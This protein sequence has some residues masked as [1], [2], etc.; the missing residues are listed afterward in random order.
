MFSESDYC[1]TVE[2][3]AAAPFE[4]EAWPYAMQ[5]FAQAGGGWGAQIM[6]VSARL[7]FQFDHVWGIPSGAA[8]DFE[9][10]GGGD[11]RINPWASISFREVNS[12]LG[13]LDLS[14]ESHYRRSEF[15]NEFL[16][17]WDAPFIGAA[18]IP[19][20]AG[21]HIVAA[22]TRNEKQGHIQ[23]EDVQNIGRVLPHVSAAITLQRRLEGDAAKIATGTLEAAA[24]AAVLCDSSGRVVS[25]TSG[26]EEIIRRGNVV[27]QRLSRIEATDAES[28]VALQR[29]LRHAALKQTAVAGSQITSVMLRGA[30]G[31]QVADIAPLPARH[32]DLRFGAACII[33]FP[34]ARHRSTRARLLISAGFPVTP[35]EAEVAIM[36]CEGHD[37]RMIAQTRGVSVETVR[38]QRKS[39]FAKLGVSSRAELTQV[40]A[41]LLRSG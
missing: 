36:L 31:F 20:P 30:Q 40:L 28:D 6:G 17:R 35:A 41:P 12:V 22:V 3:M 27:R 23:R 16:K 21:L 24:I 25:A 33:L 18:R 32:F 4:I 15:Y 38:N 1:R 8:A 13:D 29:A 37:V 11:P 9:T 7:E 34:R 2:A 14:T 10:L 5:L 19:S 26:G 39:I